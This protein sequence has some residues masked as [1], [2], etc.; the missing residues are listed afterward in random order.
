MNKAKALSFSIFTIA[1]LVTLCVQ[2]S[3]CDNRIMQRKNLRKELKKAAIVL[4]LLLLTMTGCN[5]ARNFGTAEEFT[6]H[7]ENGESRTLQ[8]YGVGSLETIGE[9]YLL[10][11]FWASWCKP[12]IR[13]IPLLKNFSEQQNTNVVVIGIAADRI[14]PAKAFAERLEINYPVLYGEY[15]L[16]SQLMQAYGNAQQALP[17]TVLINPSGQVIWRHTGLLRRRDLQRLPH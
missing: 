1:D 5:R 7:T 3:R 17:Y 4:V 10:I 15:N 16:L 13:E 8:S 14:D 9:N 6:L 11:N 2:P 12:C